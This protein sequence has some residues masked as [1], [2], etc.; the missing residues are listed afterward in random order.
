[1]VGGWGQKADAVFQLDC[2]EDK[3]REMI[4]L[5][6]SH[7][8]CCAWLWSRRAGANSSEQLR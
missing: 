3:S 1:M 4:A 6:G 5:V 8:T 2:Q 7:V